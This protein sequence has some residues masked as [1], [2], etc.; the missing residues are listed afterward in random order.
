MIK[1][2]L[3]LFLS[4]SCASC[5]TFFTT[6]QLYNAAKDNYFTD[7]TIPI[8]SSY[9]DTKSYSFL[10]LS[11]GDKPPVILSLAYINYPVFEWVSEDGISIFTENGRVIQT[12]G[13]KHDVVTISS[14]VNETTWTNISDDQLIHKVNFTN[15]IYRLASIVENK[16][17]VY[18]MHINKFT[19][20]A[21]IKVKKFRGFGSIGHIGWNYKNLYYANDQT[22]II[23]KSVQHI[24]PMLEPLHI[25][26]YFKYD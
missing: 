5:S 22:G 19:D 3:I 7:H 20:K 2:F 16:K 9:F 8:D 17:F 15:P 14:S 6:E 10:K 26:Y 12:Q 25:Q 21:D 1:H 18:Y 4:L 13:L 24:H 23:E 11:I